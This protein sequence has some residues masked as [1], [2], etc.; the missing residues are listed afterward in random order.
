MCGDIAMPKHVEAGEVLLGG[1]QRPVSAIPIENE[2][3][4]KCLGFGLAGLRSEGRNHGR[5]GA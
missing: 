3:W 2:D 4:T 5:R 1:L